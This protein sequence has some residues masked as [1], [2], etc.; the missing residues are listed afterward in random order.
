MKYEIWK[1]PFVV[2]DSFDVKMPERARILSVQL[3]GDTP[4]MW[5]LVDPEAET[6]TRHFKVYGTG[7]TVEIPWGTNC[8]YLGTWQQGGFVGHLFG[9]VPA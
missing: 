4:C 7:Q 5:A 8:Q 6:E 2:A 1:F 3:Q 9:E